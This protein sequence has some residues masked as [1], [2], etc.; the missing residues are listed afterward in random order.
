MAP[1]CPKDARPC[2]ST[3]E[4]LLSTERLPVSD[5]SHLTNLGKKRFDCRQVDAMLSDLEQTV[6][7]MPVGS[8]DER[9]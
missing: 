2:V 5:F 7:V 8:Q 6:L 9:R 1:G 3:G 4:W